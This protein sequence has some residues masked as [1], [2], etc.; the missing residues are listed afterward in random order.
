MQVYKHTLRKSTS[1]S[2]S[3][4]QDSGGAVSCLKFIHT[5]ASSSTQQ[6]HQQPKHD[7]TQ[8]NHKHNHTTSVDTYRMFPHWRQREDS[9]VNV[10]VN[11]Q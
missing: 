5:A 10:S 3:S 6:S 4:N 1:P 8:K 7:I 2:S 9:V 11:Q